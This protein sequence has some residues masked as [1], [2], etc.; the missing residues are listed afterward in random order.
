MI[1]RIRRI[2]RSSPKPQELLPTS[3]VEIAQPKEA[4]GLGSSD[5]KAARVIPDAQISGV[6][7]D[8]GHEKRDNFE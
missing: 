6:G 5:S 7:V 4:Y 3:K 8:Y 1:T 2:K